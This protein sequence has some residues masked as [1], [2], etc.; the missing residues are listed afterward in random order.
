MIVMINE[1]LY[2]R[3]QV[4][5][6]EVVVQQDAVLQ[7]LMPSFDLALRLRMIRCP[8]NVSHFLVTQPFSKLARDV[9]GAVVR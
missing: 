4:G 6:E 8:P 1:R 9:A 3:F 7:G 5:R 2:L